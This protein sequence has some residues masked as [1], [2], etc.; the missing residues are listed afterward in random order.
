MIEPAEFVSEGIPGSA[1]PPALTALDIPR[2]CSYDWAMSDPEIKKFCPQAGVELLVRFGSTARG[3]A[4]AGSDVDLAVK[5]EPGRTASKLDLLYQFG[6]MFGDREIDL[7]VLT[8]DTD[9]VLLFE[10]FS[11]GRPLYEA[12]SGLFD[13]E[14]LRALKLFYDTGKLRAFREDYLKKAVKG[15]RNVA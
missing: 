7:V 9:P 8:I 11:Q 13:A 12:R 6:G 14:R 10:I 5:M 2:S 4:R 3:T 1:R 15:A